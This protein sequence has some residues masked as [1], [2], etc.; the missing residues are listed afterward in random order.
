MKRARNQNQERVELADTDVD[1]V[2]D[3][4]AF[5]AE[6]GANDEV[7]DVTA[8]DEDVV[9][10]GTPFSPPS[11]IEALQE[12]VASLEAS[13][14]R[15][16][17]DYQNLQRRSAIERSE[18]IRYAHADLMRSLVSVLDDFER[19]LEVGG[20]SESHDAVMQ[21][22][23][24]VYQNMLKALTDA[25]LESIDAKGMPFDPAIHE[26]MMQQ[27]TD[28]HPAGTVIDQVAR[29]YKLRDRVVRPAKVIVAKPLDS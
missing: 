7:L 8:T 23:R 29:G 17:A 27:P 26:A 18:A 22:I 24:L 10:S 9:E 16:K 19:A 15:T 11:G 20:S 2:G 5:S 3:T 28:E 21:G 6:R 1:G 12:R 13:L 4:P 25:G 14:I